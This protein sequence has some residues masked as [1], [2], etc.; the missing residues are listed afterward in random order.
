MKYTAI[1]I[2]NY[3][4]YIDT[5]NCINSVLK[6]NTAPVKFFV[7]DNGSPNKK[8]VPA[9]KKYFLETFKQE[10]LEIKDGSQIHIKNFPQMTFIKSGIND[11]YACGNNKA[12]K[13]LKDDISVENILILNND[14]LFV[15]DIIPNLIRNLETLPKAA[16]VSPL[17]LKKDGNSIDYNCARKNTTLRS[18][19]LSNL[20]LAFHLHLIKSRQYILRNDSFLINNKAVEIELPS[21]SCMLIKREFFFQIGCFDSNTFLYYEENIL[22]KKTSAR[23]MSNYLIPHLRCIHLGAQ[24]TSLRRNDYKYFV[25]SY[26]SQIYY[27]NMYSHAGIVSKFIYQISLKL[28]YLSKRFSTL[29]KNN[30]LIKI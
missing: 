21:G 7:V 12:L 19:I 5:I 6:Y 24:S 10:Y 13:Y 29:V 8:C 15:Q 14:I 4:N 11:G 23:G 16:I 1:V 27:V 17:L 28:V 22:Y 18:I 2:L 20:E 26:K 25:N 9:L 3:N 30:K